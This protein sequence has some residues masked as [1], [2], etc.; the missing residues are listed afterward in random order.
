MNRE[1]WLSVLSK[2]LFGVLD[3]QLNKKASSQKEEAKA[4]KGEFVQKG[5][6]RL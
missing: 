1:F 6:D 2:V 5:G 3:K 4:V